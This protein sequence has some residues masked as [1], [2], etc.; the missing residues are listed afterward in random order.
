MKNTFALFSIKLVVLLSVAFAIHLFILN[1]KSLPLYDNK[2]LL[3]YVVNAVLAISI[4]GFLF[5]MKNKYKEQLGFL[6]LGGSAVKF[7]V[8]FIVFYPSYK[9]DG[10]ISKLEFAAFF[11]PYLLSLF[12]ETFSLAKWLNKME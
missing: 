12:L 7:V 8:F 1:S 9:V 4:F 10:D 6:F 3:A 2:I 5:K 11:V